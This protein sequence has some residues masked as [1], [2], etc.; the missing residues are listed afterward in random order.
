MHNKLLYVCMSLSNE[1]IVFDSR[2]NKKNT[3]RWSCPLTY[4]GYQSFNTKDLPRSLK[5]HQ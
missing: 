2:F 4:T 5:S 3:H 1:M